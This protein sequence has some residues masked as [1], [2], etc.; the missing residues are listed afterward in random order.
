MRHFLTCLIMTL[1]YHKENETSILYIVKDMEI[2]ASKWNLHQMYSIIKSLMRIKKE[3]LLFWWY[4]LYLQPCCCQVNTLNVNFLG[5]KHHCYLNNHKVVIWKFTHFTIIK[6][7]I[8]AKE[9]IPSSVPDRVYFSPTVSLID[10][11]QSVAS[12]PNSAGVS[13]MQEF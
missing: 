11:Q 6:S 7:V 5:A 1:I 13:N 12:C 10:R 8:A 4:I 3:M 2:F 9:S